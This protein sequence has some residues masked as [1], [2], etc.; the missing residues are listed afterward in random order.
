VG[1]WARRDPARKKEY[2]ELLEKML[3]FYEQLAAQPGTA[4]QVRV[5]LAHYH[6]KLAHL[7]V[8]SDRAAAEAH[9]RRAL[10][11]LTEAAA[12]IPGEDMHQDGLASVL[13]H[14]ADLLYQSGRTAEAAEY[15]DRG[16][17][18]VEQKVAESSKLYGDRGSLVAGYYRFLAWNRATCPDPQFRDP[19]QAIRAGQTAAKLEPGEVSVWTS[20]GIAHSRA[21]DWQAAV[22]ALEKATPRGG[23]SADWLFLA[24]AHWRLGDKDKA[25][26]WY[27]RVPRGLPGGSEAFHVRYA[28]F[29][30]EA[31]ALLGVDKDQERR[32]GPGAPEKR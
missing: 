7:L 31:A 13:F 29:R 30:A 2:H 11:L 27:D 3:G 24:M 8:A 19:A 25:R 18:H 5:N 23:G 6:V 12:D 17:R 15:Y 1:Q 10:D 20:V 9:Y 26:Q 4:P 32:D 21:G 22:A 14:L 16:F 28:G